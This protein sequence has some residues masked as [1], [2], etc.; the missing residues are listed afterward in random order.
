[1]IGNKYETGV[2]LSRPDNVYVSFFVNQNCTSCFTE[3]R[4]QTLQCHGK[5][6]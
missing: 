3:E 2:E 4:D 1:M 5:K 6:S